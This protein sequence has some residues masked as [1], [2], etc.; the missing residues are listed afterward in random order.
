[1][2]EHRFSLL[3]FP[4]QKEEGQGGKK[5]GQ[6]GGRADSLVAAPPTQATL[7]RLDRLP[8]AEDIACICCNL[9][10]TQ[11]GKKGSKSRPPA[12]A[13]NYAP[14]NLP[15]KTHFREQTRRKTA[16]DR[17]DKEGWQ[18]ATARFAKPLEAQTYNIA[19]GKG[20]RGGW[21]QNLLAGGNYK[22]APRC[23]L[24]PR[25]THFLNKKFWPACWMGEERRYARG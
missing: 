5:F 16:L 9:L 24:P 17:D 4:L 21:V 1:M 8:Q 7:H 25:G 10:Q 6:E 14:F 19:R 3:P 11:G 12:T 2:S 13:G 22:S 20:K 15:Q 18:W 23:L